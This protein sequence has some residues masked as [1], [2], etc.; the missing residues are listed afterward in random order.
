[1]DSILCTEVLEHTPDPL[2][3]LRELWRVT[4]PG[5]RLLLTVPLSEQL[6][7]EP[8]DFWRFTKYALDE[9]LRASG[10]R[11]LR[12]HERGGTWL[13]LGY[14]LSSFL[15]SAYGARR[16]AT[17]AHTPHLLRGPAVLALCAA[18]QIAAAA[19]DRA[20]PSQLST[21]GYGL[22]AEKYRA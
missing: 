16:D 10:W 12:L 8:Y 14:R 3:V 19:L 22:L 1:F 18:V 7:E 15:Y 20:F 4:K 21:I 17:G 2:Q 5:G 9:L 11:I 6:H 13:E